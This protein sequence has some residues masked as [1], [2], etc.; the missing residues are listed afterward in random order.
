MLKSTLLPVELSPALAEYTLTSK[1]AVAALMDRLRSEGITVSC[2]IEGGFISVEAR[3]GKVLP[4]NDALVMVAAGEV[5]HDLLAAAKAITGVGFLQGAKIQFSSVTKNAVEISR[6]MGVRIS[7][8]TEALRLQ[9]RGSDR[10][11][12]SRITPLECMVRGQANVL[13]LQRLPVLDI[14]IGGVALLTRHARDAYAVGQ[15]LHNCSF[16]LGANGKF[17]SDLIVRHVERLDGS[18]GWR[19]GCVFANIND[20]ALETLRHYVERNE[21][22][23]RAS[24]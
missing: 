17:V 2:F 4:E 20:D 6:G 10:V 5:E 1:K 7:M 8:P 24:C 11:K 13:T 3:I 16:D 19:Y 23:R 21:T 18:G 12:P 15:R 9:R 14:S 22:L